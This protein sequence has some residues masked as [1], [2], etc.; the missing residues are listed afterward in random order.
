MYFGCFCRKH[1]M[2]SQI[3][4]RLTSAWQITVFV[5]SVFHLI[6]S[7]TCMN[8]NDNWV[9]LCKCFELS[10]SCLYSVYV[11]LTGLFVIIAHCLILLELHGFF[12]G[13][14]LANKELKK[15]VQST[16]GQFSSSIVGIMCHQSLCQ[17]TSLQDYGWAHSNLCCVQNQ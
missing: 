13:L 5:C 15:K 11:F 16:K 17:C 2:K 14:A 4:Q 10:F 1:G 6:C 12:S 9:T 7:C 8:L 3:T